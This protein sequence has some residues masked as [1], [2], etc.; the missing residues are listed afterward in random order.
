MP[1]VADLMARDVVTVTPD[2]TVKDIIVL[3]ERTGFGGF[4]VVD[5]GKI[6]GIVTEGDLVRME[7]PIKQ[8]VVLTILDAI[9]PIGGG[10]R[11]REDL[12]KHVGTRARDVMSSPVLTVRPD[13][14][15]AQAARILVD[16]GIKHLPVIG[17]DGSLVG[18]LSRKDLLRHL[19]ATLA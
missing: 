3:W 16:R 19:A 9:I 13:T 4:P 15:A 6:V 1:S 7:S 17:E 2:T 11:L 10:K 12:L 5:A 18:I 8:P 14:D